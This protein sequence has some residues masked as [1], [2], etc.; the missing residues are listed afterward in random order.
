LCRNICA[1]PLLRPWVFCGWFYLVRYSR[2]NKGGQMRK[3]IILIY[4]NK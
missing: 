1:F 4:T 2:A 3:R